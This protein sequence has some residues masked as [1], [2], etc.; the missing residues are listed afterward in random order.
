MK[1]FK[2][3]IDAIERILK[4]FDNPKTPY[5][6]NDVKIEEFQIKMQ[7]FIENYTYFNQDKNVV[8]SSEI[9][10]EMFIYILLT[11]NRQGLRNIFEEIANL[12]CDDIIAGTQ[13]DDTGHRIPIVTQ[14]NH[15]IINLDTNKYETHSED[16][17]KLI[18]KAMGGGN[19][20][21]TF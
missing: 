12:V 20:D 8:K 5:V 17:D 18:Y 1:G 19:E 10:A 2:Q 3:K 16:I 21:L 6:L 13:H 14:G 11:A 4:F 7:E 15:K 9:L